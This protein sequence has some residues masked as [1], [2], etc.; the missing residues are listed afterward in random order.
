MSR[1]KLF[2]LM[3]AGLVFTVLAGGGCIFS[4]QNDD[5]PPPPPDSEIVWPD[6][7]E[8]LME[9]F[10][11]AYS[12]MEID[13][14]RDILHADYKFVFANG[15][16]TWERDDDLRSTENMFAGNPGEDP[17]TGAIKPG[18]QSISVNSLILI[19]DWVHES[20]THPNFPDSERALYD[21][22]IV[23]TL[24]GGENTIT[25]DSRQLF[26]VKSEEIDM[27]D[28]TTKTKFFLFGQEDFDET[29]KLLIVD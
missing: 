12:G 17:D 8:K 22:M 3:A 5:D 25:V 27:E 14:Y 6:T 13:D 4:P 20:P 29:K 16:G 19:D 28:G 26:Y 1:F 7:P 18:V 2:P 23:F 10:K 11:I 15:L 21:V 24:E 9:N